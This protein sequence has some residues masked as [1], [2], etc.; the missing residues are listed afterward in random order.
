M[1]PH[2]FKNVVYFIRD[3]D[4]QVKEII[5]FVDIEAIKKGTGTQKI[6]DKKIPT[7]PLMLQPR[8]S[9]QSSLNKTYGIIKYISIRIRFAA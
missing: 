9:E 5:R 2:V 3:G 7:P 1:M 4:P 8:L 6:A